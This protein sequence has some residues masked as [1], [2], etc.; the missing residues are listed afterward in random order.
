MIRII[1]NYT[2]SKKFARFCI[3]NIQTVCA[4]CNISLEF[5]LHGGLPSD[6]ELNKVLKVMS[7]FYIYSS[8]ISFNKGLMWNEVEQIKKISKI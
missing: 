3:P 8:V 4:N 2:S 1:H 6:S 5:Q 7:N